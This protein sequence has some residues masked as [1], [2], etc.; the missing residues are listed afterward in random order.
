LPRL[1]EVSR[2][3]AAA[4]LRLADCCRRVDNLHTRQR[5]PVTE[6][7]LVYESAFLNAVSR[8]EGLL[9]DLL[10]EFVCGKHQSTRGNRP[11]LTV[12]SRAAF[13]AIL[14]GDRPY[15][16]LM[17][18]DQ[19]LKIA[20][21]FI[22]GGGPFAE[23]T[24]D[25]RRLLKQVSII[26]NAIAHRSDKAVT[27]FRAKVPGVDVLPPHRRLPGT[28]LRR[29]FRAHPPQTWQA[30]YLETLQRVGRSLAS[31]W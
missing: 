20:E 26:R 1:D 17:P 30:F 7:E 18:Y 22:A 27:D 19:C 31:T 23:L 3:Y 9:S 15:V 25:D 11:L 2:T 21:R 14:R 6:V 5:L 10:D 8:F 24:D 12:R 4:I 16:D 13:R 29:V 28:L